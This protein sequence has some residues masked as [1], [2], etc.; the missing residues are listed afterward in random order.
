MG[1]SGLLSLL[2][3]MFC[4]SFYTV[5]DFSAAEKAGS[6]KFCMRVGLLSEQVL[7]HFGGQRSR[8]PGTK[9]ALSAVKP[10]PACVRMV[11]ARCKRLLLWRRR[12]SAFAGGRGVTLAAACN[13]APL[14]D[15]ELRTTLAGQLELRAAASTKAVWWDLRFASLLTHLVNL[16]T[17]STGM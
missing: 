9:N 6:V 8:S 13:E 1:D 4:L 17:L 11:C 10:H 5:T 12:T 15:S 16:V 14:G 7:S 2:S 3:V